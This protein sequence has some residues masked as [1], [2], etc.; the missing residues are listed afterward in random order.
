MGQKLR[1]YPQGQGEG[2]ADIVVGLEADE[3]VFR[4]GGIEGGGS[5]RRRLT[6]DAKRHPHF[7]NRRKMVQP[8][9]A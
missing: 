6:A 7:L 8:E 2:D 9:S 3:A 1:L 4:V 5:D